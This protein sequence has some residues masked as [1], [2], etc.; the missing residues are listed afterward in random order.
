MSTLTALPNT[1]PLRPRT[2]RRR[3]T[4]GRRHIILRH[5]WPLL[6]IFTVQITLS[7]RLIRTNT[8]YAD[9]ALY[10]YAGRQELNHWIHGT[11]VQD[12]QTYFSGSPHIYPPIGAIANTIGGLTGARALG[13]LFMMGATGLLYVTTA[14]LF[15]RQS[16][17][18]AAAS[19]TALGVTQ[20]LSAFA[21]YDPMALFLLALSAYLVLGRQHKWDTLTTTLTV[22]V[23]APSVLALDNATK[24][25]TA[26]W[27]PFLLGLT[28]CIP[29]IGG[30]SWRY[31]IGV[32]VRFV[33]ILGSLLGVGI[34]IGKRK[35]WQ[36]ILQTTVA[37][38]P[39]HNANMG[40]PPSLIF[41][42]TW[43]WIGILL[44]FILLGVIVIVAAHWRG[45]L[46]AVGVL[47]AGAA[48]VAPLN[49][50]RIGTTTSLQKH[51]V[52]GA[53]F[54]SVLAGYGLRRLLN[55][56]L[57]VAVGILGL[58]A[59]GFIYYTVQA[60]LLYEG[61]SRENPVFISE[62]SRL[63]PAGPERYLIEGH[64]DTVAY[65]TGRAT[66]LQWKEG[67]DNSYTYVDPQTGT[68]FA[69]KAAYTD[70]VEHRAFTLIILNGQ[71]D[72]DSTVE[73]AIVKY[74]DY[75]VLTTLPPSTEKSTALYTVW[76]L[77]GVT[78]P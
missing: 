62:L 6:A 22:T 16:G 64:S 74:R 41:R 77:N 56:R 47:L 75:H 10:L 46:L 67:A 44:I 12:Y 35:Y 78:N 25:A 29:V 11:V 53:W 68:L 20:F 7:L 34:V 54:G 55:W 40:Q 39:A 14:N 37:R 13:L 76:A 61:W 70:A 9:E 3:K 30:Q 42:D 18:L 69:G 27:D 50:A 8:A 23:V 66:S 71:E 57:P 5:P 59:G 4:P 28:I 32:G 73:N 33:G 72:N 15:D 31:G 52:L 1:I 19:F 43:Q 17:Y 58:L 49:Q 45:P 36:G 2:G 60:T 21:T 26:L 65:Y 38:N 24:Y 63:T 48:V 51:V